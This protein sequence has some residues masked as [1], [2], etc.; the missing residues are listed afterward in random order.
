MFKC[1]WYS[2]ECCINDWIGE[3]GKN[4]KNMQV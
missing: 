4:A 3:L 2:M 1:G